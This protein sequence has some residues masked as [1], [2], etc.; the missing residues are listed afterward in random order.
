MSRILT[1]VT[2]LVLL[3]TS[4]CTDDEPQAGSSAATGGTSASAQRP[5]ACTAEIVNSFFENKR[6]T[7]PGDTFDFEA[8]VVAV[9]E[10]LDPACAVRPRECV[11]AVVDT[12][13][14]TPSSK[15]RER[16]EE[17]YRTTPACAGHMTA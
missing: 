8:T 1:L 14:R 12:V 7:G 3:A 13:N 15:S 10:L 16:A 6:F 5:V 2:A 4:G 17:T 11:N 9:A